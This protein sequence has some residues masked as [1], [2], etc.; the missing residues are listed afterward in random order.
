VTLPSGSP[1]SMMSRSAGTTRRLQGGALRVGH[2]DAMP[3]PQ[4]LAEG[5]GGIRMVLDEEDRELARPT[6]GQTSRGEHMTLLDERR[7]STCENR[8]PPFAFAL[9]TNRSAMSRPEFANRQPQAE[10]GGA[11]LTV[12]GPRSSSKIG[13]MP[14]NPDARIRH[15][16]THPPGPG[17]LDRTAIG[18][19][20]RT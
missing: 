16:D 12:L 6:R 20:R 18:P 5:A 3:F 19:R 13:R 11:R 4:E 14:R 9:G 8:S 7:S 17:A 1:R 15:D 10:S 2:G